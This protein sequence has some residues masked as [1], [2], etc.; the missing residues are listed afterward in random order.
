M[1]NDFKKAGYFAAVVIFII[2]VMA[3]VVSTAANY[4]AYDDTVVLVGE[5][6]SLLALMGL[7]IICVTS[8]GNYNRACVKFAEYILSNRKKEAEQKSIEAERLKEIQNMKSAAAQERENAVSAA[9]EQGRSEGAQAAAA[10]FAQ[11]QVNAPSANTYQSVYQPY[12]QNIAPN[13]EVLYNEYGEPVMIRRRVRRQR[14][15]SGD[16]LY[17]RYGTPILRRA[18]PVTEIPAAPAHNPVLDSAQNATAN[19]PNSAGNITVNTA[20]AST[21]APAP[22]PSPV[23]AVS[24][25]PNPVSIPQPVSKPISTPPPTPTVSPKS[26]ADPAPAPAPKPT[27][28][29][30][31]TTNHQASATAVSHNQDQ[32]A[33]QPYQITWQ[34]QPSFESTESD[35]SDSS[36]G[37]PKPINLNP[38]KV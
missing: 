24:P 15:Q 1:K 16:V 5:L 13:E 18:E 32:G 17:D 36:S 26:T 11:Q 21:S 25:I 10:H 7:L 19:V 14:Q 31:S 30:I 28:S 3:L 12:A 37:S 29:T 22:K 27:P 23:P 9:L 6:V 4:F 34:S 8:K 33:G 38:Y 35:D 2:G 20:S